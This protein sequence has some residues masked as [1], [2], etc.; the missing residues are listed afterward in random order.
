MVTS[1]GYLNGAPRKREKKPVG[2]HADAPRM[3]RVR[4]C[5]HPPGKESGDRFPGPS[6]PGEVLNFPRPAASSARPP[7][8][9]LTKF[10]SRRKQQLPS[11]AAA[12]LGHI[13]LSPKWAPVLRKADFALKGKPTFLKIIYVGNLVGVRQ[14]HRDGLQAQG[15]GVVGE[16]SLPARGVGAVTNKASG[17]APVGARIRFYNERGPSG[18]PREALRARERASGV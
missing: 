18:P 15:N 2:P 8:L 12:E 5:R 13:S 4:A 3:E 7:S 1:C 14:N 9:L 11:P 16:L 6:G 17:R 10:S